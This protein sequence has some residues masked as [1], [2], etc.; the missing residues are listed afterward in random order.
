MGGSNA[1]TNLRVL[2]RSCNSKRPT[3]GQGFL[4]DLSQDGLSLDDFD[5]LSILGD[6]LSI[7]NGEEEE[8]EEEKEREEEKKNNNIP[9]SEIVSYLNEKASTNYK[10]S[11]KKT[12]D[13]IKARWNEGFVLEDFK[14]VINKKTAEW[15]NDENMSKYLR[16][17]TLFGTKFEAYLNQKGKGAGQDE[18][19]KYA[20]LF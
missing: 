9:F 4:N 10:A 13:L 2:C 15:L 11:S 16:P 20:N 14:Q 18:T 6:T 19:H 8:E 5:R 1:E 3:A 7:F 17:E 12:K